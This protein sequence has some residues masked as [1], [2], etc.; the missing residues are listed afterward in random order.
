MKIGYSYYELRNWDKAYAALTA[1]VDRFPNT[2]VAK[3]AQ[4]RLDKMKE[5]GH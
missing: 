2:T 1:V 5:E 3:L 4:I